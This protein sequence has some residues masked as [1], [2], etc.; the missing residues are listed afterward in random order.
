F[1]GRANGKAIVPGNP[2][3]SL[4]YQ[5]ISHEKDALR[6]P[7]AISKK[8]LTDRQKAVLR[9]WIEQGAQW[10]EHWSFQ[11]PVRRTPPVVK[12]Q[13]WVRNPIAAFILARLKATNLPPAAD[14]DR[15]RLIRRVSLDLTGLPPSPSEVDVFV[16]DTDPNAY[17]NL[18]DRLLASPH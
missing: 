9:R 15:R 1:T 16:A 10:K 2:K 17:E 5:R 6:M 8:T 7:P 13:S 11:P 18:V 14:A 12:A 4:L 3:A